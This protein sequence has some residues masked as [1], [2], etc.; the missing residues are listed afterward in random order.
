MRFCDVLYHDRNIVIPSTDGLI[1][2]RRDKPS[3][4]VHK[5]DSIDR[6]QML[7]ILLGYLPRIHVILHGRIQWS[8][9]PETRSRTYLNNLLIRHTSEEYVLFVLIRMEAHNVGSLAVTESL[10]TLA[11]L[12]IP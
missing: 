10:K 6:T 9:E 4:L 11:G 3:V 7:V 5:S 12:S 1:V 2:R 8:I